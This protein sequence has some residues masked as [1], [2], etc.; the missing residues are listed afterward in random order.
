MAFAQL[1]SLIIP[2]II[3]DAGNFVMPTGIFR[4]LNQK[5]LYMYVVL[6]ARKML[7]I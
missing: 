6:C 1:V 4:S 7:L 3:S 5:S 2:R